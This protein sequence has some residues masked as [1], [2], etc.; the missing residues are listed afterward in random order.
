MD[1]G[2]Y[3]SILMANNLESI[4]LLILSEV[5]LRSF[6]HSMLLGTF[7]R[8]SNAR[9]LWICGGLLFAYKNNIPVFSNADQI[10]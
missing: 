10:E 1:P 7:Y 3:A 5:F 4:I 9:M 8:R 6:A 2:A